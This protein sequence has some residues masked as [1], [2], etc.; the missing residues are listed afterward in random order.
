MGHSKTQSN[1][2]KPEALWQKQILRFEKDVGLKE[3]MTHQ[4]IKGE[5]WLCP[6]KKKKKL[7]GVEMLTTGVDACVM[8]KE[9][10]GEV[11]NF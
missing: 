1:T 2:R 8:L 4:Q 6:E 3:V 10:F 9:Q 5:V 11:L 7:S